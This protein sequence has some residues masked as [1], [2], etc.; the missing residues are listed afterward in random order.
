M[1]HLQPTELLLQKNLSKQ[2]EAMVNY[3]VGHE[4]V[5]SLPPSQHR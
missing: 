5:S 4:C 3:H 2:T 1:L